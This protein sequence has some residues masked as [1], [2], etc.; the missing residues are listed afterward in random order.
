MPASFVRYGSIEVAF[1]WQSACHLAKENFNREDLPA[2]PTTFVTMS[3]GTHAC[4]MTDAKLAI[5]QKALQNL[6]TEESS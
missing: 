2:L 3:F 1:G 4:P 6:G 5:N